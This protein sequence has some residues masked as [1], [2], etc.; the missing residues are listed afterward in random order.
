M[1]YYLIHS[2][3]ICAIIYCILIIDFDLLFYPFQKKYITQ[4]SIAMSDTNSN[5][6]IEPSAKV[7][8]PTE[9]VNISTVENGIPT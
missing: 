2:Y 4:V 3:V 6:R 7:E 5:L 8:P 1:I 9:E